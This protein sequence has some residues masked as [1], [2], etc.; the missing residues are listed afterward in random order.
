MKTANFEAWQKFAENIRSRGEALAISRMEQGF[1]LALSVGIPRDLCCLHN[2]SI[3]DEMTGWCA[4]NP[5]RLKAAK[6]AAWM[7]SEWCW[8]PTR[9]ASK[10]ISKAWNEMIASK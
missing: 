3:D 9:L 5:K 8:E 10:I 6:K 2:A 4:N 7:C 1:A